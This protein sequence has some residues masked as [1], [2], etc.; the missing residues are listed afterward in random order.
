MKV[1]SPV[2]NGGIEETCHKVTRLDP[3]QLHSVGGVSV[4]WCVFGSSG[5][6]TRAP[7]TGTTAR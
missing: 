6:E 4:G 7:S 2:L 1:A 3:T 5:P